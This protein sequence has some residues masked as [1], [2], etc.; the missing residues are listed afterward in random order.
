[1]FGKS[2]HEIDM[3][4]GP[5]LG[6]IL[7]FVIP[8]AI[9]S[10]LQLLFHAADVVVVGR[11]AGAGALAAVG[12]S[13]AVINLLVNIFAFGVSSGVNI[14]LAREYAAENYDTVNRALHSAISLAILVG[15]LFAGLGIGFAPQ[16]LTA[17]QT[18]D[19]IFPSA[20]IYLR[21]YL[22][23]LPALVV[24][25]FGAAALRAIGD[26]R[27][28]MYYLFGTGI[29]NVLLNLFFVLVMHLGVAGVGIATSIAN[30]AAVILVL[31]A[32]YLEDSCLRL[33][34]QSL[35][36]EGDVL[37]EILQLGIPAAINSSMYGITNVLVQSSVNSLGSTYIAG[38][39]VAQNLE[40]FLC[41]IV[42]AFPAAA[43]SFVSQNAGAGM[44]RRVDRSLRTAII[45]GMI[46]TFIAGAVMNL[47]S[48]RLVG[49]YNQD[50]TVIS[51]GVRRLHITFMT[52]FIEVW[53]NCVGSALRAMK[54]VQIQMVISIVFICCFRVFWLLTVFRIW[55]Y[56][57]TI[58]LIW[59]AS[60]I[61][62]LLVYAF[63]Y[64][65]IRSKY[66]KEDAVSPA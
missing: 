5:L 52:Y 64:P 50:P 47:F 32:L 13:T 24:Y 7:L 4:H 44:Y 27:R 26:T 19:D 28:P 37:S 56:Y 21:I 61:V 23:G 11:Y 31:R 16:I 35:R 63:V 14:I 33:R 41:C 54:H 25:N 62:C 3:L 34:F 39:A 12:A 59:P 30:Y 42:Y 45:S 40:G 49:I 8:S 48:A 22:A 60:W 15:V 65:R 29:L 53:L 57:E 51:V 1:M 46:I 66:P 20:L 10:A 18:P 43:L 38:N 58:A 17:M 55:H 36:L 6:P 9:T 2:S